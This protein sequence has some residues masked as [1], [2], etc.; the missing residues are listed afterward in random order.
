MS[1]ILSGANDIKKPDVIILDPP[2]DGINKNAIED[3]IRFEAQDIIYISCK[4]ESLYRDYKILMNSGYYIKK[5]CPV[6]MFPW[7]KNVETICLLCKN[8]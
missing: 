7:T 3:V 6:D 4:P 1:D 5:I 2:R 8:N